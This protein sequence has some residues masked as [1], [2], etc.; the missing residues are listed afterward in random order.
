MYIYIY[1]VSA[2]WSHALYM[3]M[4]I[5]IYM[6]ICIYVYTG[7]INAA[8]CSYCPYSLVTGESLRFPHPGAGI[9]LGSSCG[10]GLGRCGAR[11]WTPAACE[12]PW[13][14][15]LQWCAPSPKITMDCACNWHPQCVYIY[16][17]YIY[18]YIYVCVR[19]ICVIYVHFPV[20]RVVCGLQNRYSMVRVW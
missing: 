6:Y 3:Y 5:Y 11:L 20:H 10:Q 8:T 15:H 19:Y 18:I 13:A 4:Y 12:G 17:M 9:L 1:P 7:C 14:G 16:N 2:C